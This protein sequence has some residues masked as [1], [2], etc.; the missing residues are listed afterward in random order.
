MNEL[1]L[2]L[3]Y[4][5]AIAGRGFVASL[6]SHVTVAKRKHIAQVMLGKGL[7]FASLFKQIAVITWATI[8]K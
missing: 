3:V 1:Y 5:Q 7:C 4:G 2:V 6:S 8:F